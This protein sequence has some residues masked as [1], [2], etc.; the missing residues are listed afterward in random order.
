MR[1][2]SNLQATPSRRRQFWPR[3][4]RRNDQGA[5]CQVSVG[6]RIIVVSTEKTSLD[7]RR[8]GKHW[9]VLLRKVWVPSVVRWLSSHWRR[10][11]LHLFATSQSVD[12]ETDKQPC[13]EQRR[14]LP[15]ARGQAGASLRH[16]K[17]PHNYCIYTLVQAVIVGQ[18]RPSLRP[19][20]CSRIM[21][22]A[23]RCPRT[24]L[25]TT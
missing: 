2:Q 7:P 4:L 8:K 23:S 17:H 25:P 9:D 11:V 19:N 6:S 12:K 15:L 14:S 24:Y 1:R 20:T 21:S 22:R 13:G 10:L 5:C 3:G 18:V 16:P